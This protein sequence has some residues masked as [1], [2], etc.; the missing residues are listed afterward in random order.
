MQAFA[1]LANVLI[2]LSF[3][4]RDI[5]WLRLLSI[6]AGI[7]LVPYFLYGETDVL[8]VPMAWNGVFTAINLVQVYRLVMERRPVRFTEFE[9]RLHDRVFHALKP[10]AFLELLSMADVREA[11]PQT[12]LLAQGEELAELL[13][14][15]EGEV[16]IV[17]DERPVARLG[18][19]RFVGEMSFLTGEPTSASAWAEGETRYAAWSCAA[20]RE[21][22]GRHPEVHSGMQ[23]ILGHDLAHKLRVRT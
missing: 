18:E 10:R 22:F 14:I 3:L 9:R 23:L 1:H 21:F 17:V 7:T 2:L 15:C 8:W 11:G 19:D 5:L 12:K 20:L 4:V 6:L 13:L 16:S